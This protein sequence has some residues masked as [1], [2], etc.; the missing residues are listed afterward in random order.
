MP[1]LRGSASKSRTGSTLP[2][3]CYRTY[4]SQA[5]QAEAG[6]GAL[7]GMLGVRGSDHTP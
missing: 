7:D 3:G 5:G 6:C 1:V 4:A 2:A